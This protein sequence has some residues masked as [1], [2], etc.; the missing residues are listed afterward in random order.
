M[1]LILRGG[2]VIDPASGLD[3]TCDV[4]FANGRVAPWPRNRRKAKRSG[5]SPA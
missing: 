2:R 1:D 4:A 5:T 3:A